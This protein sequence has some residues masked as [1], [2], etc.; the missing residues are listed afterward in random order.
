MVNIKILDMMGRLVR[1]YKS[2]PLDGLLTFGDDLNP[3]IYIAVVIQGE[4][5]KSVKITKVN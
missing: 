2:L 3:G 5:R 4:F 1:E